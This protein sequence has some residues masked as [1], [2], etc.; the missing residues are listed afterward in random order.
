MS[1]AKA[2]R[3]PAQEAVQPEEG[4]VTSFQQ[5][6]LLHDPSLSSYH[7]L[8]LEWRLCMCSHHKENYFLFLNKF[9]SRFPLMEFKYYL[10]TI[11]NQVLD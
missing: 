10:M 7:N 9:L 5:E 1:G 6:E 3:E 11:I 2:S 4:G 8:T